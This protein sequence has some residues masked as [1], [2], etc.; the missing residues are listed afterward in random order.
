MTQKILGRNIIHIVR[1]IMQLFVIVY[2]VGMYWFVFVHVLRHI[3]E[4]SGHK[5]ES[6]EFE[7]LDNFESKFQL[8]EFDGFEKTLAALYFAM[9]SLS[10]IGFGD[11]YP[12]NNLERLLGSFMLLSG[13][14]VFSMVMG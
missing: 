5:D 13:V 12:V 3:T 14:A 10:T 11:M 9:T 6:E 2:F 4:L 7:D 8:S 1:L